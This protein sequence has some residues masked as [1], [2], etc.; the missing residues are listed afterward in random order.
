MRPYQTNLRHEWPGNFP[1]S[2][3]DALAIQAAR[4]N[5]ALRVLQKAGLPRTSAYRA[6]RTG[7]LDNPFAADHAIQTLMSE[8]LRH[9]RL[10]CAR[11]RTERVG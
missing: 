5:K 9:E 3:R 11:K 7:R 8:T 1:M 2:E 10:V 6:I 4:R